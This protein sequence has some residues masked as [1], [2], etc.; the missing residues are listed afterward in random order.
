VPRHEIGVLAQPVARVFDL[1]DDGVV[2]Q[3]AQEGGR[4]DG[5]ADHL[6]LW[7]ARDTNQSGGCEIPFVGRSWA[8]A[9]RIL[10][11]SAPITDDHG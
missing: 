8:R 3:V 11:R 4:N 1:D 9:I 5:F 10:Q 7:N 6:G 2:Q